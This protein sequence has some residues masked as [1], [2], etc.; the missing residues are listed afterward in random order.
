M[1]KG[2]HM[3][4]KVFIEPLGKTTRFRTVSFIIRIQQITGHFFQIL[5]KRQLKGH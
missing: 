3:I 5:V 1:I 4:N 2:F